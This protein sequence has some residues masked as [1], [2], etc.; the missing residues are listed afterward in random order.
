MILNVGS[1]DLQ[2]QDGDMSLSAAQT[3]TLATL[4]LCWLM[5]TLNQV[6]A[7]S[8]N[9]L[10]SSILHPIVLAFIPSLSLSTF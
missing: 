3:Y 7:K 8:F 10:P 1:P 4:H 2:S 9:K 6:I 5:G